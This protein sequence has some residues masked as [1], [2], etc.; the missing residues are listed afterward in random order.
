MI[1]W[2]LNFL[3]LHVPLQNFCV[4]NWMILFKHFSGRFNVCL[5]DCRINKAVG[6]CSDIEIWKSQVTAHLIIH[7]LNLLQRMEKN[8]AVQPL[9]RPQCP[10]VSF[11]QQPP[12]FPE[13]LIAS[14]TSCSCYAD[15][16]TPVCVLWYP[17]TMGCS[18]FFPLWCQWQG[19]TLSLRIKTS[20]T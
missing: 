3:E 2:V 20:C 7:L 14:N 13:T 15:G 4:D 12:V 18:Q 8:P 1:Q 16:K 9:S 11:P 19:V 10:S 5:F 6:N 17:Q